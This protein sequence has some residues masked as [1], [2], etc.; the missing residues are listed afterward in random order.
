M[1]KIITSPKGGKD[2]GLV[3]TGDLIKRLPPE[4]LSAIFLSVPSGASWAPNPLVH[5]R[6]SSVCRYWR[7]IALNTG[8]LW[9]TITFFDTSS[10]QLAKLFLSRAKNCALDVILFHKP[11]AGSWPMSNAAEIVLPTLPRWRTLIMDVGDWTEATRAI[12]LILTCCE[13]KPSMAPRLH[14]LTFATVGGTTMGDTMR[15]L[16]E[17]SIRVLRPDSLSFCGVLPTIPTSYEHVRHL[18][19]QC[20]VNRPASLSLGYFALILRAYTRL[21][22]LRICHVMKARGIERRTDSLSFPA[23]KE[24]SLFG[25]SL[26][27]AKYILAAVKAPSLRSL[28]IRLSVQ[29]LQH[30]IESFLC[31]HSSSIRE[32]KINR[33]YSHAARF[34]QAVPNLEVFALIG[35]HAG[36]SLGHMVSAFTQPDVV[37]PRFPAFE[38]HAQVLSPEAVESLKAIVGLIPLASLSIRAQSGYAAEEQQD[39]D[40]DWFC[41]RVE[42]VSWNL[43]YEI[44]SCNQCYESLAAPNHSPLI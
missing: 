34:L 1:M 16:V 18:S 25:G 31:R 29:T 21:E 19:L 22:T 39:R 35:S 27:M 38:I 41:A 12:S 7:E 17:R 44:D 11:L 28:Q 30:S 43:G 23:L 8:A 14:N 37:V 24:L 40:K 13:S 33:L 20:L 26:T 32:L 15:D 6:L 9:S 5:V 4:I 2:D 10:F 36:P 42:V 3:E